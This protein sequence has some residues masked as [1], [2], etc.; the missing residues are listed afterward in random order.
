MFFGCVWGR[1]YDVRD[2]DLLHDVSVSAVVVLRGYAVVLVTR[3]RR[4][5]DRVGSPKKKSVAPKVEIPAQPSMPNKCGT[6]V[7]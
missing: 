4:R 1:T 6:V 7:L 3:H 2:C 5:G